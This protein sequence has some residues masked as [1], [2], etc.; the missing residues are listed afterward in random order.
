MCK[1]KTLNNIKT[2]IEDEKEYGAAPSGKNQIEFSLYQIERYRVDKSQLASQRWKTKFNRKINRKVN[3]NTLK[4]LI[5]IGYYICS[6]FLEGRYVRTPNTNQT[7][8]SKL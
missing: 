4:V 7:I 2:L 6:A 8:D 5:L 1:C 3:V